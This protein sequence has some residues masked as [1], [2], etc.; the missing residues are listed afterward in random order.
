MLSRPLTLGKPHNSWRAFWQWWRDGLLAWLSPG[1]RRWLVGSFR[2]LI[3]TVNDV[4]LTLLREDDGQTQVLEHFD[5]AVPDWP[6]L[7]AWFKAEK[8]HQLILRFPADQALKKILSLPLAAEKNLRQVAGFE[9]DRLTPFTAAQVYYDVV[10]LERLPEQRRLRVELIALP[11]TYVDPPL[12]DMVQYGL[13]PDSLQVTDDNSEHNLLPPDQRRPQHGLQEKRMRIAVMIAALFLLAVAAVLPIWQQRQLVIEMM[14]KT[15]QLQQP[16]N[17]ALA[18]R[19]QLDQVLEA[20]RILP[21]KKRVTIPRLNLLRQLTAIL[22]E[23]T[24]LERLQ[25]KGDTL[26]LNGQSAKASALAGIIEASRLF[27]SASFTSPITTDPR[28][29]KERFMLG[30]Q[31]AR[32][33]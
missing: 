30:A 2:R 1:I 13:H 29:S 16:A 19:D 15:Q 12:H 4:Q 21:D 11:R 10:V 20:S 9:M 23:D 24:W 3:I 17:Q 18:L 5:Q 6:T 32:E 7:T 31:I 8:P 25:I 22:P 28:T 33:P 14:G 26:Q 27:N